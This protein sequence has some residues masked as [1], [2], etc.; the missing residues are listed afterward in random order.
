[1]I[2]IFGTFALNDDISG[3]FLNFFEILVF[4]AVSGVEGQKIA[5]NEK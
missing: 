1:M 4:W 2:V 5:Q 3:R